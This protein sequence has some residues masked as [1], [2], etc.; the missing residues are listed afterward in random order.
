MAE[1][2]GAATLPLL[3]Q[4][5]YREA[6][7]SLIEIKLENFRT[8]ENREQTDRQTDY[9]YTNYRGPTNRRTD[10]TPRAGQYRV[11]S[12]YL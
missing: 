4:I 12:L 2:I 1:Y 11:C 10:R 9:R 8:T 7:G 6:H 3:I 5:F